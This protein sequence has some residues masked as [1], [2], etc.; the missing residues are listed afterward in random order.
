M[1]HVSCNK[2]CKHVLQLQEALT[3]GTGE[4]DRQRWVEELPKQLGIKERRVKQTLDTLAKERKRTTLVQS[5]SYLRQKKLDDAVKSLNNLLACHKVN[6]MI[7]SHVAIVVLIDTFPISLT[8]EH[9]GLSDMYKLFSMHSVFQ[10]FSF[11]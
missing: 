11:H 10:V 4:F 7:S 1:S 3:N 2:Q 5:I 9:P 8:N 6:S